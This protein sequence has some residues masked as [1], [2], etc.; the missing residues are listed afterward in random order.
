[1][2]AV[3]PSLVTLS[4]YLVDSSQPPGLRDKPAGRT[5]TGARDLEFL[6]F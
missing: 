1:M 5:P 2:R 6:T 4:S 3:V